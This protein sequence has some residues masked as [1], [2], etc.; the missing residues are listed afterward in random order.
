M[1]RATSF[2]GSHASS[3]VTASTVTT[4]SQKTA[5]DRTIST[6]YQV[7]RQ[8]AH[9]GQTA[10]G[11]NTRAQTWAASVRSSAEDNGG[12][13]E[14]TACDAAAPTGDG[15]CGTGSYTVVN[16]SCANGVLTCNMGYVHYPSDGAGCGCKMDTFDINNAG[17]DCTAPVSLS[18][19]KDFAAQPNDKTSTTI[20]GTLRSDTDTDW[21]NVT[22]TDVL[23]AG[24]KHVSRAHRVRHEPQ[25]RVPVRSDSRRRRHDG[26]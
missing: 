20:S 14:Y 6:A 24:E 1:E 10:S 2:A 4:A 26:P 8:V 23:E 17:N 7:P 3:M 11:L 22:V 21:F 25:R 13:Y 5:V 9:A 18:S 15:C 16:G 12:T 19:L